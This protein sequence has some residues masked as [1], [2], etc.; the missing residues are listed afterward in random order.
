MYSPLAIVKVVVL[1][2]A[3]TGFLFFSSCTNALVYGP[4]TLTK[5]RFY[6]PVLPADT[7]KSGNYVSIGYHNG[8]GYNDNIDLDIEEETNDLFYVSFSRSKLGRITG[9]SYG[10]RYFNGNYRT[11]RENISSFGLDR[12]RFNYSGANFQTKFYLQTNSSF[13]EYSRPKTYFR[14]N[15]HFNYSFFSGKYADLTRELNN[16]NFSSEDVLVSDINNLFSLGS[17][18]EVMF[19]FRKGF[20][21][22]MGINYNWYLNSGLRQLDEDFFD[23]TSDFDTR[24]FKRQI[25]VNYLF[26]YQQFVFAISINAG[27]GQKSQSGVNFQLSTRF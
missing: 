2:L 22:G 12:Q 8:A 24:S 7:S 14:V 11:D 17:G 18:P 1:A 13:G 5:D 10:A 15:F 26:W 27:G 25:D 21:L 3:L 23:P 4:A 16:Q 20:G 19:N 6:L 9:F